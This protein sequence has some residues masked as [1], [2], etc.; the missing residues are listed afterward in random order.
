MKFRIRVFPRKLK[1]VLIVLYIGVKLLVMK[2]I[3][4]KCIDNKSQPFVLKPMNYPVATNFERIDWHDYKF[5]AY[6]LTR[7]GP[8]E[9]GSGVVLTDPAEIKQNKELFESEGLYVLV[10]D[11]ISVNRSVPDERLE[12]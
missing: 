9:H 4:F 7:E 10:S 6:E 8:G 11:K 12:K 2:F 1:R 3:L 5:M